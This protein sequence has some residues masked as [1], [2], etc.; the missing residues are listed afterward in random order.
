[1]YTPPSFEGSIEFPGIAGGTNWGGAAFEPQRGLLVLN[2]T[3]LPFLIKLFER[4]GFDID[5]ALKEWP[6]EYARQTGTPYIMGRAPLMSPLGLPVTKPP[7]G[8]L[9]AVDVNTG[10]LKW[11]VPLGTVRDLAPVP[12]PVRWGAPNMGGPMI[13]GGDL[14]LI[15]AAA[16]DYIRAFDVETGDEL[17]KCRLP[18]GGQATPMTFRLP[19]TGKQFVVIAA[20]GHGKLGTTIGDYVVAFALRL[21]E[22]LIALLLLNT[23]LA[24]LA[25]WVTAGWWF[26]EPPETETPPGRARR[27]GRG[28]ARCG[29]ALMMLAAV[30]F[31]LPYLFDSNTWLA[32]FCLAILCAGLL[33]VT[34]WRLARGRFASLAGLAPLLA[35]T[36]FAA[37]L[38]VGELFWVGVTPW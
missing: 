33:I 35:L 13:T 8:T 10:K 28:L 37:Y 20:G 1:M 11:E 29:A 38:Q 4:E 2:M 23:V 36:M 16:D 22:T 3:H 32:P 24:A 27:M 19:E 17:W 7:W 26:P 34:L 31:M 21:R 5:Q 14:V 18:A 25:A 9:A 12:L 6:A 30:G 15:G